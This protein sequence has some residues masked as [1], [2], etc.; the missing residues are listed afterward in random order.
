MPDGRDARH[1]PGAHNRPRQ[2]FG[3]RN[4]FSIGPP[5]QQGFAEPM[6]P[7]AF[8]PTRSPQLEPGYRTDE[9]SSSPSNR[10]DYIP[11]M[12]INHNP[13]GGMGHGMQFN[14]SRQPISPPMRALDAPM[15][16]TFQS[17][18]TMN[19][20]DGPFPA[21]FPARPSGFA[22]GPSSA[23]TSTATSTAFGNLAYMVRPEANGFAPS[24]KSEELGSSP[25]VSSAITFQMRN[26]HSDRLRQ[27]QHIAS[28]LPMSKGLIGRGADVSSDDDDDDF[29]DFLPADIGDD[30]LTPAERK[31]RA[32]RNHD[33]A[34]HGRQSAS[35]FGSPPDSKFGS[36]SNASPSGWGIL[37]ARKQRDEHHQ[38]YGSSPHGPIGS[39]LRNSSLHP[40]GAARHGGGNEKENSGSPLIRPIAR[41][42]PSHLSGDVSP[43]GMQQSPPDRR[44]AGGI[45]MLSQQLKNTRLRDQA[46]DQPTSHLQTPRSTSNSSALSNSSAPGVGNG[47]LDRAVSATSISR[48]DRI[49]E[50][51][52][53]FQMDE[54]DEER[55]SIEHDRQMGTRKNPWND[56]TA[57]LSGDSGKSSPALGMA[58][59]TGLGAWNK[60]L[61]GTGR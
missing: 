8:A 39:P 2:S 33:D 9:L 45:G 11:H 61:N 50:E 49:D 5:A 34:P 46:Q 28:S 41:P 59:K 35:V 17:N 36:P 37:H 32:S 20:Y 51:S 13:N 1:T 52:G 12:D 25:P 10:F 54:Q 6:P 30:I 40:D 29:I 47:R 44:T 18:P 27:S 48:S 14:E 42:S 56:T 22:F 38:V 16:P 24:R 19:T 23:T 31:R 60:K 15:P 53:I 58:R 57:D 55:R 3:D 7:L 21:S 4:Q 26:L 43:F